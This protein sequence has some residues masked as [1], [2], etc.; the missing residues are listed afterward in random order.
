MPLLDSRC[1]TKRL[2]SLRLRVTA[3]KEFDRLAARQRAAEIR[4]GVTWDKKANEKRAAEE[5]LARERHFHFF[6]RFTIDKKNRAKAKKAAAEN[7]SASLAKMPSK[8]EKKANA[9]KAAAE[10]KP[11][12]QSEKGPLTL[13]R[14]E[15]YRVR[16][17]QQTKAT[18][19]PTRPTRASSIA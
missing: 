5:K 8:S 1:R 6:N 12:V 10:K 16:V 4:R 17:E 15:M 3:Q 2:R 18:Q 13:G 7:K 9:E 11:A 14:E 19:K